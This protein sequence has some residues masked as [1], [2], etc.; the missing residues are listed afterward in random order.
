MNVF[1]LDQAMLTK[2]KY[3]ESRVNMFVF[4]LSVGI[5]YTALPDMSVVQ[6][7]LIVGIVCAALLNTSVVH[8]QRICIWGV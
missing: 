7:I 6:A 4:T 3:L 1:Y 2:N 5:V 8:S